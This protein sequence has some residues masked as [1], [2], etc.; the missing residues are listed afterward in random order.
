MSSERTQGLSQMFR[1]DRVFF[2]ITEGYLRIQTQRIVK[3]NT[4]VWSPADFC[5]GFHSIRRESTTR[6]WDV[7]L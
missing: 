5:D 3:L 4:L 2:A 7:G 1:H 6:T